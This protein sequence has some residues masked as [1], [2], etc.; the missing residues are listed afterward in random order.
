MKMNYTFLCCSKCGKKLIKRY[1][2]GLFELR[3][4]V[5]F[6]GKNKSEDVL[7][8][9]KENNVHVQIFGSLKIKCIDRKC[10]IQN[11]DH[12]EIFNFF[13]TSGQ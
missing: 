8:L 9:S 11:P 5:M 13:P 10:R 6:S 7:P 12:W 2:N 4:G 1:E 3:F